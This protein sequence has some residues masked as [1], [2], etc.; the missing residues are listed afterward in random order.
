MNLTS[1]GGG[2]SN[3]TVTKDDVKEVEVDSNSS[4]ELAKKTN[5]SITEKNRLSWFSGGLHELNN[6]I[7]SEITEDGNDDESEAT[8]L[9]SIEKTT[10]ENDEVV[11][12]E[13]DDEESEVDAVAGDEENQKGIGDDSIDEDNNTAETND[14]SP[15]NGQ[16]GGALVKEAKRRFP[17]LEPLE[18][19]KVASAASRLINDNAGE[20]NGDPDTVVQ[21][22][23]IEV[24]QQ[25][26]VM[27]NSETIVITSESINNDTFIDV[28]LDVGNDGLKASDSQTKGIKSTNL[29]SNMTS[30][31]TE[32]DR[33]EYSVVSNR[34]LFLENKMRRLTCL[35]LSFEV[36]A[37]APPKS[38]I[39]MD[40]SAG[41]IPINPFRILQ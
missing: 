23:S 22:I 12:V 2:A 16:R 41:N 26:Q 35:L 33:K 21:E 13:Y 14:E 40:F 9:S 5:Q 11:E 20:G 31:A 8:D 38:H 6:Q 29:T 24:D 34:N 3:L 27:Y 19:G 39:C 37:K 1:I 32:D 17:F 28:E 15:P 36:F 25:V 18:T 4:D 10:S 7:M 30:S